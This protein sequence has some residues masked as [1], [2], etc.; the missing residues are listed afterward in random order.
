MRWLNMS[1]LIKIYTVCK[2]QLF[3]SLVKVSQILEFLWY[4][5]HGN[6]TSSILLPFIES[7]FWE[8]VQKSN[9]AGSHV[10]LLA[11]P[12]AKLKHSQY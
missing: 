4:D 11:S 9:W 10:Y 6:T 1:H 8:A 5:C 7:Y 12:T 3:S 2:I